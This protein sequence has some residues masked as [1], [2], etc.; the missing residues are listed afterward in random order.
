MPIYKTSSDVN[1]LVLG[2]P[3][4]EFQNITN[5]QQQQTKFLKIHSV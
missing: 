3:F 1:P 5:K 4:I 2:N